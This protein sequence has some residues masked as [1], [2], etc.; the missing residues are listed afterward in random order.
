MQEVVF[1]Y[2]YMCVNVCTHLWGPCKRK[3]NINRSAI[4]SKKNQKRKKN[5]FLIIIQFKIQTFWA[6]EIPW[7]RVFAALAEG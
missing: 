1:Y 2:F 4:L 7:L 3:I 5:N 6:R